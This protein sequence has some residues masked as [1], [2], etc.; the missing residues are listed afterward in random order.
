MANTTAPRFVT[1][2]G[3]AEYPHI[4]VPDTKFDEKGSYHVN[5]VIDKD[6]AQDTIKKLED[7]LA[8]F[9]ATDAK[10]K[11][12]KAR[13]KTINMQDIYETC[14]GGG[15]IRLKFKQKATYTRK[16]DGKEIQVKIPVFDSKGTPLKDTKIGGGSVLRVCFTANPYYMP[17]TRSVGLSLRLVAVKVIEMKE[18]G[19]KS[20]SSYGFG[21]EEEG[22]E[23]SEETKQTNPEDNPPFDEMEEDDPSQDF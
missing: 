16:A 3:Y 17:A 4:E 2:K 20:A 9:V 19:D 7:V 1:P 21:E 15:N 18:W 14:D 22:Y 5:L 23:A 6:Q 12:A 10:F 13:G 11:E 8:N